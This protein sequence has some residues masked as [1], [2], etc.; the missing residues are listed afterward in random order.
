MNSFLE[1]PTLLK[2][3]SFVFV[4]EGFCLKVSDDFFHHGASMLLQNTSLYI[5][6]NNEYVVHGLFTII[7]NY[8]NNKTNYYFFF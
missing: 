6:N 5:C 1:G 3:N 4:F 8:V 7:Q 2:M